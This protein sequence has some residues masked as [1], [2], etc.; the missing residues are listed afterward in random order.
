MNQYVG[1]KM[2]G[3]K[4]MNRG[5]F[6]HY[7]EKPFPQ[8]ENPDEE[9]Y[10]VKYENGYESWSPKV[11]FEST[12]CEC[13]GMTFGL[14][15]ERLKKGKAVSRKKWLGQNGYI[16]LIEGA[17][18]GI[19]IQVIPIDISM[20]QNSALLFHVTTDHQLIPY[21]P[22]QMDILASD[23]VEMEAR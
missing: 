16:M 3:A 18:W 21:S 22:D 13:D 1:T 2:I 5:E 8:D 7:L 4:P 12:Y 17:N 20:I 19:N 10:L 11:T 14:A 6:Y 9:G 15:L 23:W